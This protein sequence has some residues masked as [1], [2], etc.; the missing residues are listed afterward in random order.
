MRCEDVQDYDVGQAQ[1]L[2]DMKAL[3]WP[4]ANRGGQAKEAEFQSAEESPSR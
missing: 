2:S 3:P 4:Q 1:A